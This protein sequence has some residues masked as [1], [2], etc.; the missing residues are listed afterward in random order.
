MIGNVLTGWEKFLV[1]G[2]SCSTMFGLPANLFILYLFA[3]YKD[4][5]TFPNYLLISLCIGDTITSAILSPLTIGQIFSK[6]PNNSIHLATKY[7]AGFV[8]ISGYTLISVSFYRFIKISQSGFKKYG[9]VKRTLLFIVPYFAPSLYM[10]TKKLN[11]YLNNVFVLVSI[12]L[13]FLAVLYFCQK[14]KRVLK[15]HE[16]NVNNDRT[17]RNANKRNRR[18][19][20]LINWV[21]W[22]TFIS[23]SGMPIVRALQIG[24]NVFF[25]S[26]ERE[27]IEKNY[28]LFLYTGRLLWCVN[29]VINPFLYFWK[30]PGF[31]KR[32]KALW[33]K[34]RHSNFVK[35]LP[36]S[37]HEETGTTGGTPNKDDEYKNMNA[38]NEH[39]L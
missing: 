33:R 30:H 18:A 15:R 38:K 2:Y 23:C 39:S 9:K 16:A 13:C 22:A 29:S 37:Q 12:P 11:K 25:T 8:A 26:S 36:S 14:T 10:G 20:S 5:Q 24:S 6:T 32:V 7:L 21:V 19:L 27:W 28:D 1:F 4:L 34:V 3:R 31:Y 35:V 17:K